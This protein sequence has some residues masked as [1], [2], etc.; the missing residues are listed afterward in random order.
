M[1]SEVIE[2][3]PLHMD[4]G[5]QGKEEGQAHSKRSWGQ[6]V[7]KGQGEGPEP[8]GKVGA[9]GA[10]ESQE[11]RDRHQWKLQHGDVHPVRL[12][13]RKRTGR[14]PI[15]GH[16]NFQRSLKSAGLLLLPHHFLLIILILIIFTKRISKAVGP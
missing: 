5:F 15:F 11:G 8:D 16:R 9:M 1:T 10:A 3:L 14:R 4:H 2:A 7:R 6:S 13:V 12:R